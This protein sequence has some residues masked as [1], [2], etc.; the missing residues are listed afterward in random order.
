VRRLF[1]AVVLLIIT[2]SVTL[3]YQIVR[4]TNTTNFGNGVFSSDPS[5]LT[6][7]PNSIFLTD[8][9]VEESP[10]FAN[11]N[12]FELT[13]T[14]TLITA[15]SARVYS[16]ETTDAA[17]NTYTGTMFITDD[18]QQRVFEVSVSDPT[19]VLR[20]FSTSA[21][22]SQDPEGISFNPL[23]GNLYIADGAS[24]TVFEVEPDGTVVRSFS[25]AVDDPEGIYFDIGSLSFYVVSGSNH[26]IFVLDINGNLL[27]TIDILPS[28]AAPKGITFAPCSANPADS[29]LFVADYGVDQVNDGR[30]FEIAL[31]PPNGDGPIAHAETRTGG[32][33]SSSTVSTATSLTAVAG[34]LYLAAVSTKPNREVQTVSGL[35]LAW[36]RVLA[37]CGA[38]SQMRVEVWSAQGVPSGNGVV[39]ATL[40]SSPSAAV[41]AV[42]R[43]SGVDPA[44]PIGAIMAANTNGVLGGC[45]GGI[46]S[47]AYT[48][49]LNTTTPNAMVYAAA[50]LRSKSHTPGAGYMQH[51]E[52]HA[53]SGGNAAG[54]AVM[55]TAV[56]TSGLTTVNGAFSGDV[57]WVVVAVE[58]R[59]Q[60][61]PSGN[62]PPV[63]EA[64]AAQ[65]LPA[66]T[67]VV[68]LAGTVD[69]ADSPVVTTLWT[70]LDGPD[71]VDIVTPGALTTDVTLPGAGTYIFEL[72]ADDGE[73]LSSDTVTITILPEGGEGGPVVH[74]ETRTGGSTNA[75]TV[76]TSSSLTGVAGHLYLAAISTK[77]D[78]MVAEVTGLGLAW[79]RVQGLCSGRSQTGVEVWMAQGVPNSNG[80]VT[81]TLESAPNA[82]VITVSRYSGVN[83]T[84]PTDAVAAANTNGD[85]GA[86]SGGTDSTTYATQLNTTVPDAV[87]YVAV[88]MRHKQHEP[89][90]GYTEVV[91]ATAGSGGNT[92][93]VA[94]AE[95][96]VAAPG[97]VTVDGSF[98]G[99]V[100]WAVV[101]ITLLP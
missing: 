21:F 53:D 48:E 54:V 42:S 60:S 63:V 37:L 49:S 22:G 66:G 88:A 27:S 91:Q 13:L 41:L 87:V 61:G 75:S 83:V 14:G 6:A 46:D 74:E 68:T 2:V 99:S 100:D 44:L 25:V 17:Y 31:S 10:F 85:F 4:T 34:D 35:D 76:A 70:K 28:N 16:D 3:A 77:P 56:P 80:V 38:R 33:V 24:D 64:G 94:V 47:D 52:V 50:G 9:D 84:L 5:G 101:A 90:V 86:C 96:A 78:R 62:Q 95:T 72:S 12:L 98:S 7:L 29:C 57:D 39:T 82:A 8:S 79:S 58:I 23:T 20:S 11:D 15:H 45:S 71:P 69:D 92:A 73:T 89:G 93:G 43:Y 51:T 26:R 59:P 19:T 32:S 18:D 97:L 67:T 1:L 65:F 55:D 81:A 36:T 30:L 40:E